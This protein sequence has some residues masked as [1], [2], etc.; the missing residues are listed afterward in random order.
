MGDG[1]HGR[2]WDGLDG[3]LRLRSLGLALAHG[4]RRRVLAVGRQGAGRVLVRRV[5]HVG[6][7]VRGG[8]RGRGGLAMLGELLVG[9]RRQG[10]RVGRGRVGLLHRGCS[11]ARQCQH[12][13]C[14]RGDAGGQGQHETPGRD[15]WGRVTRSPRCMP[16]APGCM[17]CCIMFMGAPL[18][19]LLP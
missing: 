4:R 17:G 5:L 13:S 1:R 16:P 2:G 3:R 12:R 11:M 9:G 14:Q 15:R 7:A 10:L 8:A 18:A 19:L 6:G